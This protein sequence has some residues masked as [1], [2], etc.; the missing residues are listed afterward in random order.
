MKRTRRTPSTASLVEAME[1]L[2]AV[3][4]LVVPM[5]RKAED[6]VLPVS[7]RGLGSRP[8]QWTE[9]PLELS[10]PLETLPMR[11]TELTHQ[12]RRPHRP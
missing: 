3:V 1:V 9:C 7:D 6:E 5:A 8:L 11:V 4:R 12:G 2:L 10:L